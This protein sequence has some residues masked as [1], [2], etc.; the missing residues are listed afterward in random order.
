MWKTWEGGEVKKMWERGGGEW[1]GGW[2][3]RGGGVMV[4]RLVSKVGG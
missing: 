1:G 2:G 3:G 4:V